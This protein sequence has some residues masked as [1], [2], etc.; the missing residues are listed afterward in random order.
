M[1]SYLSRFGLLT[2]R[3]NILEE[4]VVKLK[5]EM[6]QLQG[7]I[8]P[9]HSTWG[10]SSVLLESPEW[11]SRLI[12][13]ELPNMLSLEDSKYIS[14]ISSKIPEH[15]SCLEF[16][17]WLGQS[18]QLLK[19]G[20][21]NS[22]SLDVVDDFIWRADWMSQ[23]VSADLDHEDGT[24][25]LETFKKLNSEILSDISI[26][27]ASIEQTNQNQHLPQF[28]ATFPQG[29]AF[30]LVDCGRTFS[31]NEEWWRIVKPYLIPDQTLL[32]LQDFRTHREVPRRWWNQLDQWVASKS[33]ELQQLHEVNDGGI[34][35][36]VFKGTTS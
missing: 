5:D 32:V 33:L 14:W 12:T 10:P 19:T 7:E 6:R 20:L 4:E 29:L 23:Y 28:N 15:S 24:S 35:S 31:V 25:F 34:A 18:T 30:I 1:D 2:S 8:V 11:E 17:P 9:A 26:H 21:N 22:S 13:N 3:L 27:Q 16:G 36:F